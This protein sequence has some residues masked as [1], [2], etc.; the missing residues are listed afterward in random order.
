MVVVVPVQSPSSVQGIVPPVTTTPSSATGIVEEQT[1]VLKPAPRLS[2]ISVPDL[3]DVY[4]KLPV[5]S[6]VFSIV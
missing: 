5:I 6:N 1:V 2:F 4:S 3:Q